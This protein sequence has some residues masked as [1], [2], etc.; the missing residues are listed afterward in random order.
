LAQGVAGTGAKELAEL[1][2]QFPG[3]QVKLRVV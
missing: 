2:F 3:W 1:W